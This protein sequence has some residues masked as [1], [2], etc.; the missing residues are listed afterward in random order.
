MGG[1][2]RIC[3]PQTCHGLLVRTA[4]LLS[5]TAN[6]ELFFVRPTEEG[7]NSCKASIINTIDRDIFPDSRA[8]FLQAWKLNAAQLILTVFG[9]LWL[10]CMLPLAITVALKQN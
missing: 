6:R 4:D 2:G 7:S 9:A 8:A 5:G 1:V 10:L 3:D